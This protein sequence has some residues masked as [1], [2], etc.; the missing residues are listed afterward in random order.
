MDHLAWTC[1]LLASTLSFSTAPLLCQS[2][3]TGPLAPYSLSVAVNEVS[4]TFHAADL[5]GLPVNDLKRE[6]L[7]LRDNGKLQTNLVAF[8]P[9]LNIP[10]RAGILID[11][12]P[13]M[14][15]DLA[16]NQATAVEYVQK[17]LR[18]QSD[19]AFVMNFDFLSKISQP[20]TSDPA[21]LTQ[22]ITRAFADGRS[23]LG[24]TA[25]IDTLY[26]TCRNQFRPVATAVSG[27]F[28]MLFSDGQDNVSRASL[29]ETIDACQR[30]NTAIY[31]FRP[32]E[33]SRFSSGF[34]LL[35]QLAAQTGGAVFHADDSDDQIY[36]DLRTIE[37]NMRSQYLLIYRPPAL[38]QDGS[39]HHIE[40]ETSSRVA[41]VAVRSGYYAPSAKPTY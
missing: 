12:S 9:L 21:L 3:A 8:Q 35:A 29:E 30:T 19:L 33:Q 7:A 17:V 31:V 26:K 27:N 32:A 28:I 18:Q 20:W 36:N 4:L 25:I 10:I 24:G 22:G 13:S 34:K 37:Q 1:A 5:H 23:R 41:T 40:L 11:T 15:G 16:R 14:D 39:F 6:E 2:N 38:K